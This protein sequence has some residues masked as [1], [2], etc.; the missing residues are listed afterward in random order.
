MELIPRRKGN[1]GKALILI[2]GVNATNKFNSWELEETGFEGSVYG[3]A[4]DNKLGS[5]D[6]LKNKNI[7]E[8]AKGAAKFVKGYFKV[9]NHAEAAG[10]YLADRV[11]YIE[12]EEIYIVAHSMGTRAAYTLL[13]SF[14]PQRKT[15]RQVLLFN[16]AAPYSKNHY[17]FNEYRHKVSS[18]I[19]NYYNPADPLLSI[20][21]RVVNTAAMAIPLLNVWS[22]LT[23]LFDPIGL[24]AVDTVTEN[25]DLF[26]VQGTNH[27][28][29]TIKDNNLKFN[30]NRLLITSDGTAN[31]P[32]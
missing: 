5:W 4:W 32:I 31:L 24:K 27:Q 7:A 17:N 11:K 18:E 2:L 6:D 22:E 23:G 15:L 1:N 13:K 29:R 20:L 16:G 10:G 8:M 9:C 12:E 30:N 26:D 25:Y 28:F 19:I 3:L 14:N 21:G